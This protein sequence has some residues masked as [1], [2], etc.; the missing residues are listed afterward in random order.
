MSG[1]KCDN[2]KVFIETGYWIIDL[3]TNHEFDICNNCLR[4]TISNDLAKKLLDANSK[5]MDYSINEGFCLS[6]SEWYTSCRYSV[7]YAR[8]GKAYFEIGLVCKN[9]M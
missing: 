4:L 5:D 1:L 3:V 9:C 8:K 2:C 7:K 6:C